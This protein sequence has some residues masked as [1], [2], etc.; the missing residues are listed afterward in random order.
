L[1]PATTLL[2]AGCTSAAV[3]S[4]TTST[5]TTTAPDKVAGGCGNFF[6]SNCFV[7]TQGGTLM[8]ITDGRCGKD[9]FDLKIG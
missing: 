9:V 6:S 3:R 5:S 4:T 8:V 1:D 2:L 7:P